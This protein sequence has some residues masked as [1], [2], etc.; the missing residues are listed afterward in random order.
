MVEWRLNA[1]EVSDLV[2]R[3]RENA[4]QECTLWEICSR[5]SSSNKE[6]Y[7]FLSQPVYRVLSK[8]YQGSSKVL[9]RFFQVYAKSF[10][11]LKASKR[12]VD[13]VDKCGSLWT[14]KVNLSCLARI[15]HKPVNR[16]K[17]DAH[18]LSRCLQNAFARGQCKRFL[19]I[20]NR[21]HESSRTNV[22]DMVCSFFT[23]LAS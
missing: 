11:K 9:P 14:S 16:A 22:G 7:F 1:N 4:G 10:Y 5:R 20:E 18:V 19:S 12:T 15:Q 21:A 17:Q 13:P 6:D 2:E 23:R 8:S 3:P